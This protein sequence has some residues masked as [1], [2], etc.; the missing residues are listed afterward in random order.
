MLREDM[1]NLQEKVES[2]P[3]GRVA[4]ACLIAFALATLIVFNLPASGVERRLERVAQ[5]LRNGLGFD[6]AWGVFAP[7]PP[8]RVADLRA[9]IVYDDGTREGWR[10]PKG[11]PL[12]SEYRAYHWEKWAEQARLDDHSDLWLPLARWLAR[13]H[14]Q[15]D[16][17]PVTVELIRFSYDLNPPGAK[18]SRGPQHE[19]TFFTFHV[20][21]LGRSS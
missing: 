18:R 5:P 1:Q 20:T 4:I 17:H 9:A 11:D 19:E 6:Q 8:T 21:A 13:T 12:I 15:A 7:D 3:L 16:R 2:D 14:D 10:W